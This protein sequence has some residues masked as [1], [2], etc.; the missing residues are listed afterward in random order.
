MLD[1]SFG[2]ILLIVIGIVGFIL[3]LTTLNTFIGG[4]NLFAYVGTPVVFGIIV[5]V[6]G[7]A[8]WK[9]H[10]GQVDA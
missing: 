7:I 5:F 3:V 1:I 10:E 9:F 8:V 6:G 2:E 4:G